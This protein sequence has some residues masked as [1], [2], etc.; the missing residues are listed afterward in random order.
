MEGSCKYNE[1]AVG[2]SRQAV[3]LQLG[4]WARGLRNPDRRKTSLLR[5]V[6]QGFYFMFCRVMVSSVRHRF[7]LYSLAL[8]SSIRYAMRSVS[9]TC[10]TIKYTEFID[11]MNK[12]WNAKFKQK[13]GD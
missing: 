8:R 9:G 6:T 1:G 2:D 7:Q 12:K 13:K 4:G 11:R 5:N 3:V 10:V